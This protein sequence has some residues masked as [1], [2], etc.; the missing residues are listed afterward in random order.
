MEAA[1]LPGDIVIDKV[2]VRYLLPRPQ[3]QELPT[4]SAL[5]APKMAMRS[6]LLSAYKPA[7]ERVSMTGDQSRKLH[8]GARV[9][10]N[11]DKND[12]GT[13]VGK[14]WAGVTIK[15]DNRDEQSILHNDMTAV[16]MI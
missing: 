11:D 7:F 5:H 15:W 8:V 4:R 1:M 10:W 6:V 3:T 9:C 2:T 16:R 13:V 12:A 14:D